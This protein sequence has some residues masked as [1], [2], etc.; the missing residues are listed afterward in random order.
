MMLGAVAEFER[1]TLSD[2]TKEG[3]A[4]ARLRGRRLG[5][6]PKLGGSQLA[7]ARAMLAAP[8]PPT[9]ASIA[10]R[11]DVAP[12]TLSRALRRQEREPAARSE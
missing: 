7:E 3:L 5:R 12:W 8:M 11:F 10:S 4:A 9:L 2:R 6:P 1:R